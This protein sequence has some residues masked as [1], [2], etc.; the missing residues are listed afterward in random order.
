MKEARQ[1]LHV[2]NWHVYFL[3]LYLVCWAYN[4][5]NPRWDRL[6]SE[7]GFH[8]EVMMAAVAGPILV[9]LHALRGITE[10][11]RNWCHDGETGA[12]Y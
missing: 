7:E 9:P 5:A 6:E 8:G 3:N 11:V 10:G 2:Y 12:I 1:S 4:V